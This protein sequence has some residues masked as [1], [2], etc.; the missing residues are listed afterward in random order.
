MKLSL[1]KILSITAFLAVLIAA[2]YLFF[3]NRKLRASLYGPGHWAASNTEC[4]NPCTGN[5]N[6]VY[7][8]QAVKMVS[9]YGKNQSMHINTNMTTKLRSA[10]I[11]S[12]NTFF[13]SRFIT[14]PMDSIKNFICAI[15]N[16]LAANKPLNANG[17]P[18][19]SCDLGI[20]FYYAAYPG[21]GINDDLNKTYKGRHTL[22]LV[23]AYLNSATGLYTEFF[24]SA[25]DKSTHFPYSL[26]QLMTI[27][28][29]NSYAQYGIESLQLITVSNPDQEAGMN[30]GGL[31][32]PPDACSA[33]ILALANK[34]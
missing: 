13:D 11:G 6:W 27:E 31:C 23:P 9:E 24:P 29:A 22:V 4:A 15:D 21:L 18:I 34:N 19:R 25:V 7:L 30:H 10:G 20:K 3:D 2:V 5:I 12:L 1:S 8:R 32:P 26:D 17:K 28:N 16:M 14:F 33:E